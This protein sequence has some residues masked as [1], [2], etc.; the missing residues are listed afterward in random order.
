M[1]LMVLFRI[2]MSSFQENKML[3]AHSESDSFFNSL[4]DVFSLQLQHSS[5][6]SSGFEVQVPLIA[7]VESKTKLFHYDLILE[8]S[9]RL[10]HPP[11]PPRISR[12]VSRASAPFAPAW[13]PP[14]KRKMSTVVNRPPFWLICSNPTEH[15]P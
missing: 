12:L 8:M 13:P 4:F 7:T 2:F 3:Q 9:M 6:V 1:T 10:L 5:K 14:S 15:K 11:D